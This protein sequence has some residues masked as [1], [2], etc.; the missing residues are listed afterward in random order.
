MYI[1]REKDIMRNNIII[2]LN[3]FDK[4]RKSIVGISLEAGKIKDNNFIDICNELINSCDES[5]KVFKKSIKDMVVY[6]EENS[7]N[8]GNIYMDE[9]TFYDFEDALDYMDKSIKKLKESFDSL[10]K[11][12]EDGPQNKEQYYIVNKLKKEIIKSSKLAFDCLQVKT[13]V[14]ELL[15]R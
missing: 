12:L 7:D 8:F 3:K 4:L 11:T 15:K 10:S 14:K 1:M 13:K 2:E 6:L 9:K 5:N